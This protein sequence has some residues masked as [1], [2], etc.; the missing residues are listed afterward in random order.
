VVSSPQSPVSAA[1]NQAPSQQPAD[2]HRGDADFR[3]YRATRSFASLDGLRCFS[4]LAVIWHHAH[5]G[6]GGFSV[7]QRG[8]LGVDM[9]FVLSGF[10]IVTLLLRESDRTGD[11]SLSRFYARRTLRIFPLYYAVVLGLALLLWLRPGGDMGA[12]FFVELPYLLTYTSNWIE[13]TSIMAITWS[14]ATEEQFYLAWPPIERYLRRYLLWI[15]L[16]ALAINQAIN[17]RLLDPWLEGNLGFVSSEREILSSTFTPILLG[18]GLAHLANQPGS[19][20]WLKRLAGFRG[21]P[22]VW[23]LL[24]CGAVAWP[25]E[26]IAGLPRLCMQL[27]MSGLLASVVLR[28]QHSLRGLLTWRPIV[29]LGVVSYGLYLLHMFALHGARA[30]GDRL[31]LTGPWATVILCLLGSVLLAELS[32]RW[33]ESPI[34]KLK[35]RFESPR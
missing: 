29:R 20:A 22:L 3:A 5:G 4:I 17:F 7:T 23:S 27:A 16:G 21:A 28:E 34:L 35:Q 13:C 8:F 18:V 15:W 9:F 30:L 6:W 26:D 1:A 19:F 11:I 33:F 24:L 32:F 12:H 25:R 14:L 2:P 31:G 10:L